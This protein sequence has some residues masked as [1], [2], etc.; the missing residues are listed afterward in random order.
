LTTGRDLIGTTDKTRENQ[1]ALFL[2]ANPEYGHQLSPSNT[3]G[4]AVRSRDF[5]GGFTPLPGTQIE[6]EKIPDFIMGEE[7]LKTVVTGTNATE[8]AVREVKSPRI[9]HLATHGFFLNDV[10]IT[11]PENS[12]GMSIISLAKESP[13]KPYENPLVRSGLAFAGANHAGEVTEGDDGLLTALEISGMNLYGTYLV[14]LSACETGVG[15]VKNGEGV[16]G[17]RRAF[18][19]AGAKNL[20]MSLWPVSD[21]VTAK[22]M[23]AFYKNLQTRAPA[24]A[25]RE[26]QLET[27]K[28]LRARYGHAP[29]SLWA[30][31]ILQGADAFKN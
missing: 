17:L 24:D 22:Q 5:R 10:K 23:I 28:D 19:L 12:R 31:F 2:A 27:I 1:T 14:V 20:M 13:G 8:A 6:A 18:A 25:L 29:V 7:G 9:L 4:S 21:A 30:P 3:K 15:D 11:G 16:F 26:A